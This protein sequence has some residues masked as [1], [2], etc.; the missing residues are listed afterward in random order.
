MLTAHEKAA[1]SALTGCLSGPTEDGT[2]MLKRANA[3]D[4]QLGGEA[5][6]KAHV[7]EE[8]RLKGTWVKKGR[9]IGEKENAAEKVG[10]KIG[11]RQHFLAIDVD[12][13]A[14]TCRAHK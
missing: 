12:K 5:D 3:A 8:V 6:L 9:T 1:P 14:D 13:I 4:V 2:Y 7:G 10:D 11:A